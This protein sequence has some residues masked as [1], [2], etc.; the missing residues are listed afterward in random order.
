M[1]LTDEVDYH[2]TQLTLMWDV[3]RLILDACHL[4]QRFEVVHV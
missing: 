4:L 1:A 2:I 3:R